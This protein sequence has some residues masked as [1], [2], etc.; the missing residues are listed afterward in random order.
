MTGNFISDDF[1]KPRRVIAS[2]LFSVRIMALNGYE[3]LTLDLG[4]ASPSH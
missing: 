3:P 4:T 2:V 1:A